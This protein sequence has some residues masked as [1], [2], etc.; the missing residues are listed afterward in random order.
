MA[1]E[2]IK[3]WYRLPGESSAAYE[4]FK[5]YLETPERSL[6]KVEQK[7]NKKRGQL[8]NWS[9]KY[10]WVDR[11]AAYDSS[12]VEQ[13]RRLKIKQRKK[14]LETQH[15][16]GL[17]MV[18]SALEGLM[19]LDMK[20]ASPYSI[21]QMADVGCKILNTVADLETI[22]DEANRVTSITIKRFEG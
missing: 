5:M 22:A 11:A 6:T 4:A 1:S 18:D 10:N 15:K 16:L 17:K 12:I 20:K 8:G 3:A 9:S 13:E 14:D 2:K 21:I 7:L 19:A